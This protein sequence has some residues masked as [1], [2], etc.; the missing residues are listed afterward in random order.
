[1][2]AQSALYVWCA[3]KNGLPVRGFIWNYLKWKPPTIPEVVYK[4]TANPRFSK[5]V[6]DTDYP[7]FTRAAKAAVEQYE[8]FK[9]TPD[10]VQ[11][12]QRLKAQRYK[13]GAP[14][15]SPFFR[16]DILEKDRKMLVQVATE[17]FHTH[18][19]MA[20]YPFGTN[21]VERVVSRGC[22]FD[23]DFDKLCQLELMGGNT[24]LLRRQDFTVGDP[25]D[26]YQDRAGE[27]PG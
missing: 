26:Y 11:M 19:R 9:I 7:T 12:Q 22:Q 20:E 4:N 10:V 8:G 18:K 25:Q 16:R 2:D 13:V 17:N 5:R 27:L 6:T 23:C 15:S 24:K 21:Q 1:L 14:Q 3:L